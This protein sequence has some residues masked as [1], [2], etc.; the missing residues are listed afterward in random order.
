MICV[1]LQR[2]KLILIFS[3]TLK[4]A[5]TVAELKSMKKEAADA[6]VEI[7][8]KYYMYSLCCVCVS[9]AMVVYNTIFYATIFSGIQQKCM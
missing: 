6:N 2:P 7:C 9:F 8:S 3:Y 4:G 5:P 1:L